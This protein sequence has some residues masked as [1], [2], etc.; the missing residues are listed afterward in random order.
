M[1]YRGYDVTQASNGHITLR[2]DG[3]VVTHINYTGSSSE[4]EVK[5]AVD[6]VLEIR[7][8]HKRDKA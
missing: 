2:K 5:Q 1:Q 4:E 7:E 3:Q 6:L 8:K